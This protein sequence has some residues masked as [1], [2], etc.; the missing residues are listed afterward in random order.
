VTRTA[1]AVLV[2]GTV[3]ASA[4]AADYSFDL[5]E[6]A[7]KPYELTGFVEA[8][9]EHFALRPAA[10]L[11]PITFSGLL[12]RETLD[13]ATTS[14]E[15]A[16]KF[17]YDTLTAYARVSGNASHDA[18]STNSTG[19]VL[20]G[21][22][23]VSP[24]EGLIV[25][26]GKQVQRW[27]K[28]Y[29][30][31]PVAFFERPKDPNDP[32]ASREGFVMASADWVKSLSGTVAAIGLTPVLLPVSSDMNSDFGTAGKDNV[33]ARLYMLVADTDI[34]LLW[35]AE[36]SRPQRVG[37][38]FSRNLGANLEVHGEWAR[39]IGANRRVLGTDGIVRTSQINADS[40]LIGARYIT[41]REVTW[42]A[43]LYRNGAGYDDV[44]LATYY[45]FLNTAYSPAGSAMARSQA[46]ALAQS[47]YG[48]GNP[49]RN[50]AYLRVSAKDPFNWLYVTPAFTAIVNLDDHSWQIAPEIVYTGWQNMEL[51]ARALLL[52]GGKLSE[53]GEKAT[54]RRLELSLRMYF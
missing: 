28:G 43:E 47:G 30:W 24:S 34:D 40:W 38:D 45:S 26:M 41:E 50:Y 49:G 2:L 39:A 25:D 5:S 27:G 14:F 18:F 37:I 33:G 48:R 20:E 8:K 29:A 31:N 53:F 10:A 52:H 6:V 9:A 17:K 3:F 15:L 46:L 42:I 21:G 23:R 4:Q 13:R 16:G 22:L 35:A 32:A 12:P 51:R 7:P 1:F 36:G 19:T 11:Y 54:A 44:Q